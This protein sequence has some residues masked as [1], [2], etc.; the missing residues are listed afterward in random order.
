MKLSIVSGGFDP[1][2][3]GHLECFEKAKL[4][5]DHLFVIVNNDD[6]LKRKK[7]KPFMP[8]RER[9][10]I[11][12]ALKPVTMS[13]ACT[14]E[15]DSVCKTLEW[16]HQVFKNRY[17]KMIFC[18]GGDRTEDGD[19]PEHKLCLDLGIDP[20]YGLGEKIQSSRWLISGHTSIGKACQ[21]D[22]G[23]LFF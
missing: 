17:S 21:S 6:F 7:S 16:I 9:M 5:A 11:T 8:F 18:N 23:S 1:V 12:Q 22:A 4:L 13:I 20:V 10:I 19:K 14:D 2:H 3:V 15:D